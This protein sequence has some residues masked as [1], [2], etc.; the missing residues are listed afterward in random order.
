MNPILHRKTNKACRWLAAFSLILLA[1][2]SLL[3]VKLLLVFLFAQFTGPIISHTLVR[4]A[5][6]GGQTLVTSKDAEGA[7]RL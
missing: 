5:H 7:D 6:K 1:G 3:S 4:M 2:W